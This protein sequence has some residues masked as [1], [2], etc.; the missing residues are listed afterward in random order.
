MFEPPGFKIDD[1]TGVVIKGLTIIAYSS[2]GVEIFDGEG[3]GECKQISLENLTI[4]AD[5]NY[6]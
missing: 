6:V 4:V 1:C 2:V 3:A 5:G